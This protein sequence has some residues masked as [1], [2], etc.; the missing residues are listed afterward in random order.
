MGFSILSLWP[1]LFRLWIHT[2]SYYTFLARHD[3]ISQRSEVSQFKPERLM[4]N[5][6]KGTHA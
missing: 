1:L 6:A 2:K 3:Y 4:L 5:L